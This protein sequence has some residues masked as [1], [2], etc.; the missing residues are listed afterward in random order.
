MNG[1]DVHDVEREGDEDENC[2]GNGERAS[3]VKEYMKT[4]G[5][6]V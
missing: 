5:D 1:G 3:R 6:G 4:R 2:S